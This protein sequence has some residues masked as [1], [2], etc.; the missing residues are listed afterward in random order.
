[1]DVVLLVRLGFP[2]VDARERIPTFKLFHSSRGTARRL[3]QGIEA[4]RTPLDLPFFRLARETVKK[5][6][7][8][9]SLS[10]ERRRIAET[11]MS[12]AGGRVRLETTGLP[13]GTSCWLLLKWP[14][15]AHNDP[16]SEAAAACSSG[17]R[18]GRIMGEELC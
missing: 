2:I 10:R 4:M 15:F 5:N 1:M 3:R 7:D 8:G 14:F 6:E 11:T 16:S 18:A 17:L 12:L 13:R 9:T